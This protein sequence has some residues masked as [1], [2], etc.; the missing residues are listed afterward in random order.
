M[1]DK[2]TIVSAVL[3]LGTIIN[4]LLIASGHAP[5]PITSDQLD[6]LGEQVYQVLSMAATVVIP[7]YTMIKTHNF[8]KKDKNEDKA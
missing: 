3:L 2:R 4:N 1:M 8:K 7:V 5:L 6:S